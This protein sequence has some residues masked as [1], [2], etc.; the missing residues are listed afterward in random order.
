MFSLE[1]T[2][3]ENAKKNEIKR[4]A[5]QFSLPVEEVTRIFAESNAQIAAFDE[6]PVRMPPSHRVRAVESDA[7][8]IASARHRRLAYGD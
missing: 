3:S 7:G 2:G 6:D 5:A 8:F 4:L 1:V